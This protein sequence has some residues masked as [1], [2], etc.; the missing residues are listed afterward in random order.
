MLPWLVLPACDADPN[1]PPVPTFGPDDT[2]TAPTTPSPAPI[3]RARV[4][5]MGPV[6]RGVQVTATV[7]PVFPGEALVVGWSAAGP[8]PGPCPQ[9]LRGACFDIADAVVQAPVAA[10]FSGAASASATFDAD[11][12]GTVW[13]QAFVVSPWEGIVST[14]VLERPVYEAADVWIGDGDPEDL[15]GKIALTGSLRLEGTDRA[16]LALPD[17]AQIGGDLVLWEN[18]ALDAVSL[19]ALRWIGGDLS[20]YDDP[21]LAT[22]DV[23]V[24][25]RIGGDLSVNRMP[26]VEDLD[27][28]GA[29]TVIG[30]D[31]YVYHDLALARVDG[32]PALQRIGGAV[33]LWELPALR[34][35]DLP[36]VRGIGG[37]LDLFEA[38]ALTTLSMPALAE[39]G[40]YELHH[41]DAMTDVGRFD[42]LTAVRGEVAVRYD[43]GLRSLAGFGAVTRMGALRVEFSDRL[44]TLGGLAALADVALGVQ[45]VRLPALTAVDLPNLQRAGAIAVQGNEGLADVGLPALIQVG[46]LGFTDNS[47]LPACE[48]EAL[49]VRAEPSGAV[50]CSGNLADGCDTYCTEGTP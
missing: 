50:V 11:T 48:V 15:A 35:V 47:A 19:P 31:L 33:R 23:P 14:D 41:C 38:D 34:A 26:A 3:P 43:A 37:K 1:L 22:L 40:G 25:E 28:F 30:G 6:A 2:G 46:D 16:A 21:A 42:A 13:I 32:M 18:P 24:L 36:E 45:V 7:R 49:I 9:S 27:A 17:L 8:G 12:A 5:S 44:Q 4:L 20:T 29:L 10:D 39:L